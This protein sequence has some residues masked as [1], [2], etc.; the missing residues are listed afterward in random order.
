MSDAIS[1]S[2]YGMCRPSMLVPVIGLNQVSV[3][4]FFMN[5]LPS[6]IDCLA[7]FR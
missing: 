6:C 4:L 1:S 7:D 2:M 5:I 3:M